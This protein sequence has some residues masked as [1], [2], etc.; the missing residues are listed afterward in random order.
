LRFDQATARNYK[1]AQ[2]IMPD[3][4]SK[5]HQEGLQSAKYEYELPV[6]GTILK[7]L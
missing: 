2:Q 4:P 3:Y 7:S 5:D 6:D 1:N